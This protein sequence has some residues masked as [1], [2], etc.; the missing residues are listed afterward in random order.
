MQKHSLSIDGHA[1]SVSLEPEFWE[2]LK[3][4]AAAEGVSLSAL[5]A[6]IDRER[7]ERNLCSSLRLYVLK[8]LQQ[9]S[10]A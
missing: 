8:K 1:T 10:T 9:K 4:L 5:A 7:G 2:A 3:A 6:R